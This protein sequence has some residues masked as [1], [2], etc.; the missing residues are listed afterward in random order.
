MPLSGSSQM[1]WETKQFFQTP[2]VLEDDCIVSNDFLR[3]DQRFPLKCKRHS[4]SIQDE[5][6]TT[7]FQTENVN[8]NLL[9]TFAISSDLQQHKKPHIRKTNQ[10]KVPIQKSA[11][12]RT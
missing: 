9:E 5:H 2:N 1:F 10:S 7:A 3:S 6:L 11:I 12:S 4:P 8:K